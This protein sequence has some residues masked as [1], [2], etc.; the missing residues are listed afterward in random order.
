MKSKSV[1]SEK[2]KY[3]LY[4]PEGC[5]MEYYCTIEE[6]DNEAQEA[7]NNYLG[8]GWSEE[9]ERVAVGVVTHS[10]QCLNKTMRP[11]PELLD[12][13]ECD[14]DGVYWGDHD[15]MGNYELEPVR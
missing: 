13:D 5:G 1:P 10:A 3:W 11:A 9:V 7:I 2:Y 12:Y 8:D 15:W 6:R 4:D 14:S